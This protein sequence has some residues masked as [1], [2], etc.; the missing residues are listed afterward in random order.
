LC[1]LSAFGFLWGEMQRFFP[2]RIVF[3]AIR[4]GTFRLSA[5]SL[6]SANSSGYMR[7]S[8]PDGP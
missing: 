8:S 2:L 6:A 4:K 7:P 5:T 3:T 1:G